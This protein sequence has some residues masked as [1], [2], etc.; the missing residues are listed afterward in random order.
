MRPQENRLM[1]IIMNLRII[2]N[3][4]IA[5]RFG[6][7][8]TVR[9]MRGTI[10]MKAEKN[11][12]SSILVVEDNQDL[13]ETLAFILER[14]G[15]ITQRAKTAR[16]ALALLGQHS[17]DLV[18]L[19]IML[20]D[21]S[22]F[23]VC[24]ILRERQDSADISI[25]FLSAKSEEIDKVVGFEIGADDYITKPFSVKELLLRI[26]AV[27]RRKNQLK[28]GN[29]YSFGELLIDMDAPK[30]TVK[31]QE[32]A[33]TALELRLLHLLYSRK[34]RVQ[35]RSQ[36]LNNVWK[37]DADITTRTVDTHIK[38]L[39]EKLQT[40]GSYIKTIRGI[41]YRFITDNELIKL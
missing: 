17:F 7:K 13:M 35:T 27:L 18:L 10:D 22:G 12:A 16:D 32:I 33:L 3:Y 6:E 31:E 38:R 34:G 20:P 5:G 11:I 40:A 15:F 24:R 9:K 26:N 37:I 39:R 36:L 30:V 41:G 8:L 21:I 29:S 28:Q 23:E 19:D 14:G 4:H 2:L 25:I 1:L